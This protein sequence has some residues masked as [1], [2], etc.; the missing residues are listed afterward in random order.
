VDTE[1]VA[2]VIWVV[3]QGILGVVVNHTRA[4]VVDAVAQLI[5]TREDSGVFVVTVFVDPEPISVDVIGKFKRRL[6]ARKR[7]H[8]N[9][10]YA[11]FVPR[12]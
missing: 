1:S 2:I 6:P 3:G 10:S 7:K 4:V 12:R 5:G 11:H 9:P 8:H